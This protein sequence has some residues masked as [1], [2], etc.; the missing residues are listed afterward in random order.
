MQGIY[1]YTHRGRRTTLGTVP[2]MPSTLAH[3]IHQVGQPVH[4]KGPPFSM[5]LEY[6]NLAFLCGFWAWA[7]VPMLTRCCPSYLPGPTVSQHPHCHKPTSAVCSFQWCSYDS[8]SYKRDT[9]RFCYS[10]ICSKGEIKTHR[11]S[12][13]YPNSHRYYV[14]GKFYFKCLTHHLATTNT[15]LLR[16]SNLWTYNKLMPKCA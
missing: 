4:I 2:L 16:F 3:G 10:S 8:I 11:A 12:E 15:H 13:V 5:S 14:S 9:N 1:E 7:Q 6:K